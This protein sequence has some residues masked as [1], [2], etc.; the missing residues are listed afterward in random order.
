MKNL[1]CLLS[2]T[3]NILEYRKFHVPDEFLF[4]YFTNINLKF[5]I[6]SP[7]YYL[8][9]SFDILIS[10]INTAGFKRNLGIEYTEQTLETNEEKWDEALSA[11]KSNANVIIKGLNIN[12]RLHSEGLWKNTPTYMAIHKYDKNLKH[13]I[14][15][16]HRFTEKI[17]LDVLKDYVAKG[18]K[19][20]AEKNWWGKVNI[21]NLPHFTTKHLLDLLLEKID[22]EEYVS[23]ST[24]IF[25]LKDGIDKLCN[26]SNTTLKNILF[27]NLSGQLIHP[28]GPVSSRNRLASILKTLSDTKYIDSN[29]SIKYQ[30]IYKE[31]EILSLMFIKYSLKNNED[32][33]LRILNK[34]NSISEKEEEAFGLLLQLNKE[35]K[36]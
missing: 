23:P 33:L 5:N 22:E 7:D 34:L 14:I 2:V 6:H 28:H 15:S 19:H 16:N 21:T 29:I 9:P 24:N 13:F 12:S 18:E 36:L 35:V 1:P 30:I 27:K 20:G 17:G 3:K 25:N 10:K 26:G 4:L 32:L 8:M 31:W 11:V